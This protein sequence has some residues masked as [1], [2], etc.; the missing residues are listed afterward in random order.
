MPCI[1]KGNVSFPPYFRQ[2][3]VKAKNLIF[4]AYFRSGT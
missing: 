2:A 4:I 3:I 1:K